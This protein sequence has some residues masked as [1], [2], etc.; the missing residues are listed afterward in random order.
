VVLCYDISINTLSPAKAPGMIITNEWACMTYDTGYQVPMPQTKKKTGAGEERISMPLQIEAK[1][2][3]FEPDAL[4]SD[5]GAPRDGD[6]HAAR[7]ASF[8]Q[9][10]RLRG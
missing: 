9:V 5:S 3:L 4:A 7:P 2:F 1:S 8:A 6:R 10:R